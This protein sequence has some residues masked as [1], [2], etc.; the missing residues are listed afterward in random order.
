[1]PDEQDVSN[2]GV[3]SIH[4]DI[5]HA[6]DDLE[7][8]ISAHVQNALFRDLALHGVEMVRKVVDAHVKV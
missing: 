7:A 5:A 3:P 8:A 4:E 6:L 2:K 1:M